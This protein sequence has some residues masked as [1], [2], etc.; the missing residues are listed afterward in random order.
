MKGFEGF[1]KTYLAHGHGYA[2]QGFFGK[3]RSSCSFRLVLKDAGVVQLSVGLNLQKGLAILVCL[4]QIKA[5]NRRHVCPH[6]TRISN[7]VAGVGPRAFV[8]CLISR[9]VWNGVLLGVVEAEE[10]R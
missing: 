6:E 7:F 2:G 4:L 8:A 9:V 1:P 5:N 10:P 3:L